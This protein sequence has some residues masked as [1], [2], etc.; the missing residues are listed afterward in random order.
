LPSAAFAAQ[1]SSFF[2][3]LKVAPPDAVFLTANLFKADTDPRK[4]NLGIGAYRDDDG[5]PFV[6][7]VVKKAEASI[8]ADKS[9]NHE[10][11][12]IGGLE[13]FVTGARNLMFGKD[14]AAVKDGRIASFQTISGTG[15]LGVGAAFLAKQ[16]PESDVLVSSPTWGNHNAIFEQA[17][18]KKVT[19]YR[20]WNAEKRNLDIDGLLADLNACKPKTIVLLH[21]CAHN[22]TGVDPTEA[23]W[24]QIL[25]VVK[26]KELIPYMDSAYQVGLHTHLFLSL[27]INLSLSFTHTRTHSHTLL[28]SLAVITRA[29]PPATL[30]ATPSPRASSPPRG[31]RWWPRSPSPR[32]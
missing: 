2:G 16:Y 11:L 14:S 25:D 31:W 15:S 13:T 24:H 8:Q 12:P 21:A 9:L 27:S 17:G 3:H 5:K 20:Y 23:Q 1:F 29:S 28:F 22:P 19:T 30:R 10:Y 4:V 26:E 18:F 7:E 6:L 32:T